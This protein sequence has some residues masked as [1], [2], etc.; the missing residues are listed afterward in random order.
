M[1]IRKKVKKLKQKLLAAEHSKKVDDGDKKESVKEEIILDP[2]LTKEKEIIPEELISQIELEQISIETIVTDRAIIERQEESPEL[3][4]ETSALEEMTLLI[5]TQEEKD[6]AISS[7]YLGI[8]KQKDY[9]TYK[10]P[11][12]WDPKEYPHKSPPREET[13]NQPEFKSQSDKEDE[14]HPYVQPKY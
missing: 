10:L 1:G 6:V 8:S 7:T 4:S 12:E 2:K 13:T 5:T 11:D 9:D 14:E 3:E